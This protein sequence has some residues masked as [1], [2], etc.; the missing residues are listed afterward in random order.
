MLRF[1]FF[2]LAAAL[3][4]LVPAWPTATVAAGDAV[5][6]LCTDASRGRVEIIL[7]DARSD[8]GLMTVELYD[9]NP[10]GF[11]KKLGR[12]KRVRV[13]AQASET[14]LCLDAPGP[15]RYAV[16]VYHD[17]NGNRKFDRN[18]VGIPEEGFGFSRNPKLD[19][20]PP[21]HEEAAFDLAAEPVEL[22]IHMTYW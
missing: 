10:E 11:I 6:D 16:T 17:E 5:S 2:G 12:I 1:V 20:G 13:P 15:G 8:Q 22:R 18:F 19:F 4:G 9:D 3:I 7:L 14:R 21:D